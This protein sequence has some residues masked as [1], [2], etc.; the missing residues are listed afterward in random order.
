MMLFEVNGIAIVIA[1]VASMALGMAWYMVLSKP[2]IAATGRS[3]EEI[4]AGAGPA[5]FGWAAICQLV[6]AVF[7]A[8]LT[9]MIMGETNWISGASTGALLW[10]GFIVTSMIINHRYQGQKWTLTAI[11]SGYLL[12]VALVQGII[13]GLFG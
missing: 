11:D 10:G 3:E 6:M 5:P 13:I 1:T 4:R 2:W 12:G 9:P 7:I 8:R